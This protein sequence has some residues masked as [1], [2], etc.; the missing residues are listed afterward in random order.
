MAG[1]VQIIHK[2]TFCR[3]LFVF[4]ELMS[5]IYGHRGGHLPEATAADDK[6]IHAC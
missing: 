3:I 5:R 1:L 4:H 2:D 6:L